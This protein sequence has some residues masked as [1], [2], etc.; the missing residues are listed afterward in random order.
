MLFLMQEKLKKEL[1]RYSKITEKMPRETILIQGTGCTWKKCIFCDYY[2]DVSENPFAI[3]RSV[4]DSLT[5]EFGTLDVSNS[6]SAMEIDEETLL[7]LIKKVEGKKINTVWFEARWNY[8]N[9]FAEFRKKFPKTNIKFRVGI[10]TFNPKLREKWKKGI[11]P[12][13]LAEDIAKYYN[14]VSL[15]VGLEGQTIY[16]VC[17]DIETADKYFE[18]FSLNVF[19][20]NT[21][22]CK[23]NAEI[24]DIFIKKILPDIK[25]NPK[26][27]IL[28]ENTDW[29][30]G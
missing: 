10:E 18:Y 13:V 16:D 1:I 27:D 8:R 21:T 26:A 28:L 12:Y 4:I 6:G 5:G 17:K 22:S 7:Y 9:Q 29:G 15:M 19:T 23:P 20:P 3:N 24:I 25:D 2:L 30:I 11:A 14:G